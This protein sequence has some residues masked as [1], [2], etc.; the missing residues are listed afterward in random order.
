MSS[1]CS[2]ARFGQNTRL[3]SLTRCARILV[4]APTRTNLLNYLL[5]FYVLGTQQGGQQTTSKIMHSYKTIVHGVHSTK[6][7]DNKRHPYPPRCALKVNPKDAK[8]RYLLPA[9]R[10]N[11]W[12]SIAF[13]RSSTVQRLC[14]QDSNVD[15]SAAVTPN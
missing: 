4:L 13:Q 12:A 10:H 5:T 6:Q 3:Q 2:E 7:H 15:P 8:A 9:T 14:Q 1:T 11:L